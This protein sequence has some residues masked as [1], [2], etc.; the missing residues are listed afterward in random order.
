VPPTLK[1]IKYDS[2]ISAN[3]MPQNKSFGTIKKPMYKRLSTYLV[4]QVP[5]NLINYKYIVLERISTRKRPN[6][7]T[8]IGI[9]AFVA[10]EALFTFLN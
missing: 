10:L 7:Y 1:I 3:K 8:R 2:A 9:K 4:P 5:L 6:A